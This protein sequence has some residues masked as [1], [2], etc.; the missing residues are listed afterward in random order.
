MTNTPSTPQTVSFEIELVFGNAPTPD[1][2][3]KIE[4][5]KVEAFEDLGRIAYKERHRRAKVDR[6]TSVRWKTVLTAHGREVYRERFGT[7]NNLEENLG[8]GPLDEWKP[9]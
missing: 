7:L 6:A 4:T 3:L 5:R 1:G 9:W 2:S 8:I